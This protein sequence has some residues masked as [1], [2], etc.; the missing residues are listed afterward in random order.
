[1][2]AVRMTATKQSDVDKARAKKKKEAPKVSAKKAAQLAQ[3]GPVTPKELAEAK[4]AAATWLKIVHSAQQLEAS[5][6]FQMAITAVILLAALLI[7]FV[8]M[9]PSAKVPEML[10]VFEWAINAIFIAEIIIK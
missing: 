1:M 3:W 6:R 8:T 7:G 4:G 10:L 5:F 2:G 9:P